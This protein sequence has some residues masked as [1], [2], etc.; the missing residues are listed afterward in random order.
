M[1]MCKNKL[2]LAIAGLFVA[3]G[4]NAQNITVKGTVTDNT[5]EPVIGAGVVIKGTLKGV[6]TNLDGAYSIECASNATLVFSFIGMESQEVPVNGRTVINV[7]MAPD[8]EA[9]KESVVTA[10]GMRR[11]AKAL[12][13]A[14]TAVDTDELIAANTVSPVASL[15]GKVA[16]VEINQSDGG[17]FGSTKIQIRGASTLGKNNQ[18][19]Y[20]I[21]G[22][23][24]DNAISNTGDADW[25]A[26]INDYGN[27]LK[28]LNPDDF[29]SLT[30][31]KGAAA[32]AL[33]GSRGLNGAVVITTKQGR[34]NQGLGVT[35][36]QTVGFDTVYDTPGLQSDYLC[37]DFVGNT[38]YGDEYEQTGNP[39]S[40]NFAAYARNANGDYS[41]YNQYAISGWSWGAPVSA[42]R[43]QKAELFDG[44]MGTIDTYRNR[45]KDAFQTGV[46]TN[47]H[48]AVSGGTDKTT[49][50]ASGSYKYA[51]GTTPNNTFNRLSFLAK[52]SHKITEKFI[53]DASFN[54][55]TSTPRNAQKNIGEYF[56]SSANLPAEYNVAYYKD[57]YKGEHGGIADGAY[58]D[59]YQNVPAKGLW[60]D[61]YENNYQQTETTFR[62]TLDLTYKAFSWL[63]FKVGANYNY[64]M[65]RG[66]QKNPG[67]GYANQGGSYALSS[68][69]TQQMNFY[70]GANANYQINEDFEIHGFLRGEYFDQRSQYNRSATKGGLAIPLQYFIGN[71]VDTADQNAYIYG[72]K[73][74]TSA[75]GAV[76]A[77][78]RNQLFLDLTGRN[79]WSSALVYADGTGN[80]SYF[81]P[82]VSGSWIINET[83]KLPKWISFMKIRASWAQV[84]ND[85]SPYYINAGYGLKKSKFTANSEAKTYSLE[86]N[87]QIKSLDLRPER[88]TSWEVGLDWRFL[89][90]RIGLDFTFYKENTRDQ[91]MG[92]SVPSVS[93]ITSE[94]INA[95]DIQNMGFEVALNTTP[96]ETKDWRWDLDFTYTRNRNKIISLHQDVANWIVLDGSVDYGNYRIG[97]VAKVGGEYGLLMTDSFPNYDERTGYPICGYTSGLHTIFYP[98]SGEVRELGSMNPDFLGSMNTTLRYKNVALRI[99][100]D[101]RFGGY[102]ASYNS[103]YATA[104]G[105]SSESLKYR[106]GMQWTSQIPGQTYGMTFYDGFIPQAVFRK[107]TKS[108]LT[109]DDISGMT[110]QEA[111]DK[112][113]M[114]PAHKQAYGY[115]IN[116]WG[117]GVINDDWVKK[118]N[119]I[120]LREV[121]ISWNLPTK[122][123]RAIKAQG[124]TLSATGRNL[125]YLLNTAPNHENPEA[126]RGTG[127]S[128]FRMRSFSPYTRSFLFTISAQF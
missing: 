108:P 23:I 88:K 37:G 80:Y 78:W 107:G 69:T 20:V 39:W 97:S 103:R 117:N 24:L 82:S 25:D 34:T 14:V 19:I 9:L 114:E 11:E 28:N 36:S 106:E 18:P 113:L 83:F 51:K 68:E 21:D 59:K 65:I 6:S 3:L 7:S 16:G 2:I 33:Y 4:L 116:S 72:T 124:L 61:V 8:S 49:F 122:W 42:F 112:G 75:V 67:S 38:Y 57:K 54:F 86:L 29:A 77:S 91:I 96:I 47:T 70:Y 126:V 17:L 85:T 100:M 13:Y 128:N 98:R 22:V 43:G 46:N 44:T 119:Y 26:N 81:Y 10:L 15:Q 50:Y 104:Y 92:V 27:Q 121:T 41:L 93:G 40:N 52:A 84:G 99:S 53:V 118:L 5:G 1:V 63:D 32:T 79:D 90:N 60:W 73:R 71:S 110:Y 94:L 35:F 45:Y 101:A 95:G 31:L 58:G 115:Y 66:E 89:N 62:P 30:V 76:G 125:A 74:I 56:A 87:N 105:L 55:T 109:G 48:I 64:Y 123:A 111:Y 12:G 102:V 120:A 127:S